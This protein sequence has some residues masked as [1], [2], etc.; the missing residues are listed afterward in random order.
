MKI[1]EGR[2]HFRVRGRLHDFARSALGF[3][4]LWRLPKSMWVIFF[5]APLCS[6]GS[7]R[8][9]FFMH[10]AGPVAQAE[11]HEF[12]IVALILFF[13]AAPVFLLVPLFAWHYRIANTK[14]AFRPNWAFSWGLEALIWLPPLC[15]VAVLGYFLALYTTKLDPYRPIAN[16][17]VPTLDIQV[18]ALDWKWLFLYPGQHVATVNQIVIPAG[19]PVHFDL[20]SATVMQSLLMPQLAGQ[21]YAM[22]GMKTQLNFAASVPGTYYGENTQYNGDGFAAD[23]FVIHAI[24]PDDF[25]KW[26]TGLQG[27]PT[28]LNDKIY[29]QLSRQS[30]LDKP[31]EF[32]QF[33]PDLFTLILEQKIQPGYLAQHHENG[34]HE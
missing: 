28:V 4:D 13:V 30:V 10:P 12:L 33:N 7:L 8:S 1:L 3:A 18:V 26:I 23:K 17:S 19:V 32:G 9:G 20:T 5:V 34:S 31:L 15:I 6:C 16:K 24:L 21:I 2:W 27:M 29:Q 22:G 25:K 11:H 14:A